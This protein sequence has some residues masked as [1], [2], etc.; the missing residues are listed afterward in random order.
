L[1][2]TASSCLQLELAA[3]VFPHLVLRN[4]VLPLLRVATPGLLA[5]L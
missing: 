4:P 1:R 3:E 5:W 2:G